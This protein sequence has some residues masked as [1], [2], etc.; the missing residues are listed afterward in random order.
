MLWACPYNNI[1]SDQVV[2]LNCSNIITL[3]WQFCTI[4]IAAILQLLVAYRLTAQQ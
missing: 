4:F 3:Q 1:V 2:C